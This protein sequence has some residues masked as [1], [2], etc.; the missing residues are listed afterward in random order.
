MSRIVTRRVAVSEAIDFL[1]WQYIL[2]V[3]ANARLRKMRVRIESRR[4]HFLG[5]GSR[6]GCDSKVRTHV[7]GNSRQMSLSGWSHVVYL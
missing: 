7:V 3:A 1:E 4:E 5:G 6:S 2:L